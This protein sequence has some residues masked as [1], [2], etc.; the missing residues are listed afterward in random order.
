MHNQSDNIIARNSLGQ[1]IPVQRAFLTAI[2]ALNESGARY[3]VIGGA[4]MLLS[5][6]TRTPRDYDIWLDAAQSN[7]AAVRCAFEKLGEEFLGFGLDDLVRQNSLSPL[8]E[9]IFSFSAYSIDYRLRAHGP[10]FEDAYSRKKNLSWDVFVISM[11][12]LYTMKQATLR[13]IDVDDL[14][15]LREFNAI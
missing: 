10:L 9:T 2:S 4:A 8:V 3:L 5:G 6:M 7:V 15:L 11:I 12:D 14:S 1:P 13:P